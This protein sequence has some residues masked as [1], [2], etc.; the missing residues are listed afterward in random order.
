MSPRGGHEDVAGKI[1]AALERI[2]QAERV[3]V[4]RDAQERGISPTQLRLLLRLAVAAPVRRRPGALARELDVSAASLSDSIAALEHKGLIERRRVQDDRRSIALGLTRA[5][6]RLAGQVEA[7]TAPIERAVAML[8]PGQ[9]LALMRSLFDVIA[10]LQ[11]DGVVT[12]AR[13]CVTCRHF[14]PRVHT[15]E[16]PHHCALLDVALADHSLRV[17][18]PEHELAA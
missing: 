8:P 6:R 1:A 15:G 12:V 10:A 4:Q 11:R 18:C 14:R 17:D 16:R 2:G 5:G 3:L 9:Q 13:M 7:V